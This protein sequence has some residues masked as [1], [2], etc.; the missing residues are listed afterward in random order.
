[1][2]TAII[3]IVDLSMVLSCLGTMEPNVSSSAWFRAGRSESR[4]TGMVIAAGFSAHAKPCCAAAPGAGLFLFALK[5]V[6]A[7]TVP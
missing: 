3:V 6:S 1:M 5:I 2:A 7:A 4:Q